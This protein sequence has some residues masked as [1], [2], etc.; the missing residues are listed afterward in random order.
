MI[1]EAAFASVVAWFSLAPYQ[2]G[3]SNSSNPEYRRE[4]TAGDA[5]WG[6]AE[7]FGQ[8]KNDEGRK[9]AL[10]Y[11]VER[12]PSNRHAVEARGELGLPEPKESSHGPDAPLSAGN[13]AGK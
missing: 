5:L 11:L 10:K 13:D 3:S 2:C 9:A 7:R 12:Y 4:D 1:R 8:D 6:L